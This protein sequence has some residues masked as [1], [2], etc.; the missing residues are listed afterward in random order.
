[1]GE[2][3]GGWGGIA[4]FVD[5]RLVGIVSFLRLR[6]ALMINCI[7]PEKFELGGGALN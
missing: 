6:K 7:S 4:D 5:M 1:M 2:W 3:E